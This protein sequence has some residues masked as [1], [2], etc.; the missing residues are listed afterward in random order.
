M[1]TW[2]VNSRGPAVSVPIELHAGTEANGGR[3]EPVWTETSRPSRLLAR[4]SMRPVSSEWPAERLPII[5][6]NGT[7]FGGFLWG[8]APQMESM[9]RRWRSRLLGVMS[10]S[11]EILAPL[12]AVQTLPASPGGTGRAGRHW[13]AASTARTPPSEP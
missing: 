4:R 5:W 1:F 11:E 3:W 7:G 6:P 2:V 12:A 8:W 13:A 9:R 10:M